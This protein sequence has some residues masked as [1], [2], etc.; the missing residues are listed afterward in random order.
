MHESHPSSGCC[1]GGH[2]TVRIQHHRAGT[3]CGMTRH[4]MSKAERREQLESYR[5]Q[6]RNELT[7]VEERLEELT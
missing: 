7:A 1:E 5:D 2:H 3:C 4:F 6:L